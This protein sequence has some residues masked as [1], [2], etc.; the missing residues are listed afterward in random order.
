MVVRI[1][2]DKRHAIRPAGPRQ[3][4]STED[5]HGF[6]DREGKKW[7]DRRTMRYRSLYGVPCRTKK[8][9]PSSSHGRR[10][11]ERFGDDLLSHPVSGAVPLAQMGLTSLFGMG[12]GVTP[13]LLSPKQQ[14]S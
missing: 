3:V 10:V 9:P 5:M 12:R 8:N 6:R 13:P 2:K 14:C 1:D 7:T 4:D 11:K